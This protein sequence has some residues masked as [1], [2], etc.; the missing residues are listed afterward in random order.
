MTRNKPE[1]AAIVLAAGASS[2][3]GQPKHVLPWGKSTIIGQIIYVLSQ[4]NLDE[5]LV[6][7]G[8]TKD[9]IESALRDYTIRVVVNTSSVKGEMLSSAQAGL[10]VLSPN[11]DAALIT[12]GDQP[13]IQL[14]VVQLIINTYFHTS[15]SLVIPSYKMQRGHPWLVDKSL[16]GEILKLDIRHSLRDFLNA[17]QAKIKY[18]DVNT[19]S[20][21]LDL[22]TPSDYLDYRSKS[23]LSA[24]NESK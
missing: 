20:I 23:A 15:C 13:F 19:D 1:V 11:I 12:L 21:L 16:W 5:I 14:D 17:N 8:E 9:I 2:R 18:V 10:R 6:V 24:D 7:V 4:A 22:D 3:M